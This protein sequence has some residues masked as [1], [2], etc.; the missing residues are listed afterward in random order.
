MEISEKK[1]TG[2]ATGGTIIQQNTNR[3]K[4]SA[5]AIRHRVVKEKGMQ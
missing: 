4:S 2:G 3:D 1:A 5:S